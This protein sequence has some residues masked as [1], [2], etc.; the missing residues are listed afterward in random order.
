MSK[1]F[2]ISHCPVCNATQFEDFLEVKDWLVSK[3]SF[4]LQRCSK[5]SFVFT[6]NAPVEEDIAP[7]Y[8]S[9]EYVE[10]SDTNKGVIYGLYHYARSLMLAY[11]YRKLKSLQTGKKLLDVGSGSGYFLNFMKNKGYDVTGVE[12]SDKAKEL[13]KN[14]FGIDAFAPIDFLQNKLDTDF[15]LI[16]LWHVFE[17]VYT[18]DAYFDLF[19]KSLSTNGKLVLALPNKNSWDA[20]HYKQYW[21]AYD[22]P[23]HLWHFT[24]KTIQEFAKRRGF[25]LIRRY[26]LPLDP[27]F[28]SM[29]SASY[30]DSKTLLPL[31][32]LKGLW[33]YVVSLTNI[34]KSSS[35]IYVFE[36][37]A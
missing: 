3:E 34:N 24:P 36:K 35:L 2:N 11:K 4:Q 13:C 32:L 23:R 8:D 6:A 33:S 28:N 26:R 22:T 17:H 14:K 20:K 37:T 30:Q 5:C 18:Y 15:N 7:Y 27:F 19:K 25:K 10:H 29:V 9:E 1:T 16:T 31:T 21:A 12:I